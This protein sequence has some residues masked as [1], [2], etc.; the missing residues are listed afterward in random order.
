MLHY[1]KSWSSIQYALKLSASFTNCL[2]FYLNGTFAWR[3]K[4]NYF[5]SFSFGSCLAMS[6]ETSVQLLVRWGSC[7]ESPY[8]D[9]YSGAGGNSNNK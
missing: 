4:Q 5:D 1:L 7:K 8:R 3:K 6:L 9:S 2:S